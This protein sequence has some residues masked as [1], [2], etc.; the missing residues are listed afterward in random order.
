MSHSLGTSLQGMRRAPLP[1]RGRSV[2]RTPE[3]AVARG[4]TFLSTNGNATHYKVLDDEARLIEEAAINDAKARIM[5]Q[6]KFSKRM[7]VKAWGAPPVSPSSLARSITPRSRPTKSHKHGKTDFSMGNKN[8]DLSLRPDAWDEIEDTVGRPA[9][10]P[11]PVR[12]GR[13]GDGGSPVEKNVPYDF[14]DKLNREKRDQSRRLQ[15]AEEA[16]TSSGKIAV[17]EK[18]GSSLDSPTGPIR[19]WTEAVRN[20]F[21]RDNSSRS[22][23]PER[24]KTAP[25]R[26]SNDDWKGRVTI[27]EPF[28]GLEARSTIQRKSASR[29]ELEKE[30][31]A[32][33]DAIEAELRVRFKP[34][35]IPAS[36]LERRYQQLLDKQEAIRIENHTAAHLRLK[37]SEKPFTGMLER[38]KEQARKKKARADRRKAEEA[39]MKAEAEAKKKADKMRQE[40]LAATAV[41]NGELYQQ[42]EVERKARIAR[43]AELLMQ[44]AHK[45][46][47]MEKWEMT[48]GL[49][50]K[51]EKIERSRSSNVGTQKSHG[52]K[53]KMSAKELRDSFQRSQKRFNTQI[54]QVKASRPALKIQPFSFMSKEKLAEEK[55]RKL[56]KEVKIR[57][58][59]NESNKKSREKEDYLK[60]LA[61]KLKRQRE[62]ITRHTMKTRQQEQLVKENM[63]KKIKAEEDAAKLKE[64]KDAA[65]MRTSQEITKELRKRINEQPHARRADPKQLAKENEEQ[66]RNRLQKLRE[67]VEKAVANRVYLFDQ[68]KI[69]KRK[70]QARRAALEKV[71]AAVFNSTDNENWKNRA[72]RDKTGLFEEEE[73]A[74]MDVY[75]DEDYGDDFEN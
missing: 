44:K 31:Q 24:P 18:V 13:A 53:S 17:G 58:E 55:Q 69:Q 39:K 43:R 42:Q 2:T 61:E 57:R 50:K 71:G 52:S 15:Q 70:E 56:A 35:E 46:A 27:P 19:K 67:D 41:R 48:E 29:I 59:M 68:H 25:V 75:E 36:T 74:A 21:L 1:G 45:P 14:P 4:E 66:M 47:R 33:E 73:K 49:R 62:P 32:K 54:Q 65:M 28:A 37:Q 9:R 51:Q 40:R 63:A 20:T 60:N 64:E 3:E 38:E 16:Y 11:S 34:M 23:S 10:G 22:P 26:K 12:L 8:A 7:H 5:Q 30:L 6:R 72:K